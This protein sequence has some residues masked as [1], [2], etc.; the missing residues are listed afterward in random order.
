MNKPQSLEN[1]N[2]IVNKFRVG[3]SKNKLVIPFATE[4]WIK[5]RNNVLFSHH[6]SKKL[7][8][9]VQ[10]TQNRSINPNFHNTADSFS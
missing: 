6:Y 10:N 4:S 7:I 1:S 5:E 9:P 8:I 2:P 3:G